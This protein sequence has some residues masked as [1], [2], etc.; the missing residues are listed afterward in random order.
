M[1]VSALI[2]GGARSGKTRRALTLAAPFAGRK[3]YLATAQAGDAEMRDRIAR[4]QAERDAAWTTIEEPL[5]LA[6]A[7]RTHS[8][9]DTLILVDCLTLWL[10]NVM[11]AGDDVTAQGAQ[12]VATLPDCPGPVL[13]V[14]NEVGLGIV[15]DTPLGR[16][17]RD[18]QG[19]LNQQ[20]AAVVPRVEFMAAGLPLTLKS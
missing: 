16:T 3:R 5:A 9:P 18:A 15:P 13:L 1:V 12:L 14:S 10:S 8:T 19:F 2:L 11:L 4:H 6:K 20:I 7:L 17:F